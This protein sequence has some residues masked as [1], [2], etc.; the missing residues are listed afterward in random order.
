MK[1]NAFQNQHTILGVDL[2]EDL[3]KQIK[4]V[5]QALEQMIE[6]ETERAQIEEQREILDIF[7]L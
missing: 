4:D 6:E 3:E 5:L 7:S 2:M 1:Y